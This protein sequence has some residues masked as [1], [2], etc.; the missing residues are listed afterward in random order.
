MDFKKTTPS[1]T[2]KV[3]EGSELACFL[4][5]TTAPVIDSTVTKSEALRPTIADASAADWAITVIP[6]S[7]SE[8][9]LAEAKVIVLL[10]EV[11][12]LGL[13]F[14]ILSKLIGSK[15]LY[16]ATDTLCSAS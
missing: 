4:V 7:T 11:A 8:I 3:K 16:L 13:C 2:V 14:A 5:V 15:G 10:L 12:A 1:F 6:T 9:S